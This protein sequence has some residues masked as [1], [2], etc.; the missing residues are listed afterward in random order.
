M[1]GTLPDVVE[2][3]RRFALTL[4]AAV[5]EFP[6]GHSAI[7]VR[8]KVFVFLPRADGY[9]ESASISVKLPESADLALAVPGAAPTGYGLGRAGWVTLRLEAGACPPA[10]LLCEWVR[11]S[12][13][14]VAPKRLA[15][16][17]R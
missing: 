2:R 16:E 12:Y 14:A 1:P 10:D 8:K 6:W 11:E 17:A 4:P 9:E 3:V 15:S 5:E 7:K 13:R